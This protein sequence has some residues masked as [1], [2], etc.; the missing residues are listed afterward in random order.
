MDEYESYDAIGLSELVQSGDATPTAL[1]DAAVERLEKQ[2][3]HL[4]AVVIPM[5]EHAR[6]AI[7]AG[8]PDGPLRGVQFLLKDLHATVPGVRMTY[9]S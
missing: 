5:L 2:N 7:A 1:L 8:L 4:N 3:P 6:R 9:G